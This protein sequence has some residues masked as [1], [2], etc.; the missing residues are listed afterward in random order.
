MK[1]LHAGTNNNLTQIAIPSTKD[2]LG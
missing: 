2:F 1:S